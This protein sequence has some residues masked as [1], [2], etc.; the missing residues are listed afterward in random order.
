MSHA[1]KTVKI[2]RICKLHPLVARGRQ[3]W[4]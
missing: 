3:S 2:A 1:L 4:L